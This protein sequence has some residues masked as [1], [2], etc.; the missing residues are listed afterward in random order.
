MFERFTADARRTLSAAVEIAAETGAARAGPEHLLLGLA[1]DGRGTGARI[2]AGYGVTTTVLRAA[3]SRPAGRRRLT[4]DE[5]CA[6]RA[7]GVDAE[8]VFRRI[9]QEFGSAA[10]LDRPG[11]PERP[12]RHGWLA[13]PLDAGAR[14]VVELCLRE[15]IA[16]RHREIGSGHLLLALLRHDRLPGSVSTTLSRAGVTYR[17]A[18]R[19]VILALHHPG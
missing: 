19:R 18:R 10:L 12:R 6:L 4:D 9:E 7:V 1:A 16:L 5:I 11:P 2:L 15:A 13:G 17:D 14:K 3:V 8:E